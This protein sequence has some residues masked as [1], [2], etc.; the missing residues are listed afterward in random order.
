MMNVSLKSNVGIVRRLLRLLVCSCL[1]LGLGCSSQGTGA[2][3]AP[4]TSRIKE[5]AA[6]YSS[7]MELHG[8]RP[9]ASEAEFKEFVAKD[10][11]P[12]LKEAGVSA[13]DDLFVSPR[14]NQPY[15]VHYGQDAAK[16][17]DR[18]PVIYER[19]GVNGRRLVG[20]R[21]G[22]VNEVDE[23]EFRELVPAT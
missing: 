15:V 5:L 2:D 6:L 11:A 23:T 14:D 7:Y 22:Y 3:A 12:L 21:L 1:A 10:G 4:D 13:V 19:N 17:L 9:P 16:R 18:G 8:R 20:H